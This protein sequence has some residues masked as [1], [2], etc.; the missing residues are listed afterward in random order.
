MKKS[1]IIAAFLALAAGGLAACHQ[2]SAEKAGQAVDNAGKA[3]VDKV[4][5]TG[6]AQTV[7]QKLDNAAQSVKNAGSP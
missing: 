6:P 5:P 3:V 7:G 4:T 2:G 1:I